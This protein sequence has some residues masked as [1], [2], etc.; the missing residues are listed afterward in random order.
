MEIPSCFVL[1]PATQAEEAST[2][3]DVAN[4]RR[5]KEAGVEEG[6]SRRSSHRQA[7]VSARDPG[8][9]LARLSRRQ[10]AES[11]LLLAANEVQVWYVAVPALPKVLNRTSDMA[12]LMPTRLITA[13]VAPTDGLPH[14]VYRAES[15]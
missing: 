3:A 8:R 13:V 2:C 6:R 5:G 14:G 15:S 12:L 9:V 4:R 11:A 10:R 1:L 7:S